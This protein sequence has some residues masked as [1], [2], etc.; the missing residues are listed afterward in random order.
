MKTSYKFAKEQLKEISIDA[1]KRFNNDKPA[2]RQVI[3]DNAYFLANEYDL[4]E[5]KTNL[6]QNYA[7]S[8][9]P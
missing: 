4:N 8:L 6:L 7:G 5:Y 3:N 9:H 1:K 2:I